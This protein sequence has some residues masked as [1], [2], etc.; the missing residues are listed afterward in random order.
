[1]VILTYSPSKLV[2]FS[3]EYWK[4][5]D[6]SISDATAACRACISLLKTDFAETCSIKFDYWAYKYGASSKPSLDLRLVL[7]PKTRDYILNTL[8]QLVVVFQE[9]KEL[10]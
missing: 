7:D 2:T 10:G 8:Q 6:T 4:A 9:Y 3:K 1:M 5:M